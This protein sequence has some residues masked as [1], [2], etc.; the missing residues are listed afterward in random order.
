MTRDEQ[1]RQDILDA[2]TKIEQ[3]V[4][5]LTYE[6]FIEDGDSY[7]ACVRRLEIIG[8]AV[9]RLSPELKASIS[10]IPWKE[11]AGF[12]DK[13]IHDYATLNADIVWETIDRD[14]VQLKIA[15]LQLGNKAI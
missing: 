4:R 3:S 12:R 15:L 8:E 1:Y 11:I 14:I 13:A 2:I 5:G 6:A 9:K 10:D 7:D